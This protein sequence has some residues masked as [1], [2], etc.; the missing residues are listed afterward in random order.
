MTTTQTTSNVKWPEIK[1]D[2]IKAWGKV[3]DSDLE[4]TKGDFK[5]ISSLL[6]KNYGETNSSYASKL[7]EIFKRFDDKKM[8]AASEPVQPPAEAAKAAVE[9]V[10]AP[11]KN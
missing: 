5:E 10:K 6:Q 8:A 7:S 3:S 11:A 1:V 2:I 9:A 4:N